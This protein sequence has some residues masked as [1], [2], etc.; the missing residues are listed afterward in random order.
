MAEDIVADFIIETEEPIKT[1][2]KINVV[3]DIS[4]LATKEELEQAE[5]TL[6]DSI[7]GLDDK[8]DSITSGLSDSI[9]AVDNKYDTVTSGLSDSITAIDDKYDTITSGLSDSIVAVDNKYDSI[10]GALND[11]IVA[12]DSVVSDNY[13]TLDDKIDSINGALS[14]SITALDSVVSDN[15]N[16]LDSLIGGVDDKI[17]THIAD[18]ANPHEVT[19]SQVGLGNVDNT[20]DADKPISTATQNALDS[21]SGALTNEETAR[22]NADNGL[23]SQI[24]ALVVASDVFDIVGTYA[25]LQAYDISTVPVNDIIKVLVDSTHDNAATYYRCTESGGVKSWTY[26]GAEGAYYTKSEADGRFVPL[27]REINGKAL[28]NNIS[29][30]ASDVGAVA[31]ITTGS[32]N[33]TISVDGT[34]VSVKGLNSAAYT[35]SSD[36]ATATQGGKADSAIQ[37]VKVN[38]TALTPDANKAVDVTVPTNYVTTDT[39]QN[40]TEPKTFVGQK[41]I[42]FK[43]AGTNDKLGFTL[44]NNSGTEKGYLEFNP[45]N[46]VD[47]VPLMTLGNY[48]SAA[49]GLTHVGFRKYSSISGAS[50][51]Y[52]LLA[53]LISDAKTPFSL[54]TTYTNFYLPLGFTDGNTTV[55]TAKSGLVNISTLLPTVPSKISDLTDDTAT[56]PIDKADTLTGL[57]ASITELNYVDG[58]TS[59]IQ[60]QLDNKVTKN[61]TITGATKCKI[62]YDSK[63]LVTNGDDLQATDIPNLTLSKITD[64]TASA[65][66]LNILDGATLTTTELNY[67]DGVTSS[68]QT[69][70]N[71]KQASITGGASTITS[72]NLTASKA[73]V[74]NVSGKVDVSTVTATELGYLSGVTSSIQTQLSGKLTTSD[75]VSSVSSTSTNSKAV[76]AKLFYDTCGDIETLINAL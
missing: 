47:S 12:L 59:A 67:V 39:D 73:L 9:T 24:D 30:T 56:Y 10:T 55:L 51:A 33:G 38:G 19:A 14:D 45:S 50:G 76:G 52:N 49:T 2:F 21:I 53:P 54:T 26:I 17:D 28:S 32:E 61:T 44:Y 48:A 74:S 7:T 29:L 43:Q 58:V 22:Q 68:I 40:I 23:Q 27:T 69:Q 60:T 46:T 70:L 15:Y 8:Y 37:S 11:S 3:P 62:T 13:N 34:D 20:S 35:P 66:E 57:T 42:A 6:N 75:I 18:K 25:E 72:S 16:T 41:R 31:S 63:G 65:S 4:G 64:V 71:S 5:E 1:E 36:Y